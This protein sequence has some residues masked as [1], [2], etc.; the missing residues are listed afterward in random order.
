MIMPIKHKFIHKRVKSRNQKS[1]R[2]YLLINRDHRRKILDVKIQRRS[3]LN[4]DYQLLESKLG[5]KIEHHIGPVKQSNCPGSKEVI[6]I[7]KLSEMM[8][9]MAPSVLLSR[10]KLTIHKQNKLFISSLCNSSLSIVPISLGF[11]FE[12]TLFSLN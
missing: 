10:V 4:S 2:D 6:K 11:R 8:I 3:E 5:F 12:C 7:Y 9:A 1:L